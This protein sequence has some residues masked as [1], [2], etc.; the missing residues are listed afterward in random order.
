[1]RFN[2]TMSDG[3]GLVQFMKAVGEMARGADAPFILPVWQR[4][5][6]DARDPPRITCTHRE[7]DQVADTRGALIPL[8]DLDLRS[9]FFGP[10]QMSALRKGLPPH[11]RASSTFEI[12]TACL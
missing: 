6:L 1:M 2:H 12:L 4:E 7:Y 3:T 8:D 5:L 10:T 9:F 11:Q